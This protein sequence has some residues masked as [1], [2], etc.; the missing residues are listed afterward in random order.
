MENQDAMVQ[1]RPKRRFR[2]GIVIL[3]LILLPFLVLL[4]G[5]GF[6]YF[7]MANAPLELDDPRQ[8]VAADPISAEERFRFSASGRTVQIRMEKS[9]I[10][11]LILEQTGKDFPENINRELSQWYVSVS[12]CGIHIDPEGIYVDVELFYQDIRL[13]AKIP[14]ALEIS[15]RKLTLMPTG[16]KLGAFDL[17]VEELL[18]SAK[19]EMELVLPVICDVTHMELAQDAILLTGGVEEDIRKLVPLDEKYFRTVAFTDEMKAVTDT[20][21]TPEDFSALL[22]LLEQDPGFAETY[23]QGLFTVAEPKV[24]AEYLDKRHGLTQRF[25]PGIDF[26]ATSQAQITLSKKA[27][28]MTD[29]IE[30]YFTNLTGDYND[31]QFRLSNGR[32][33]LRG[34]VFD[35]DRY[36]NGTYDTMFKTLDPES[37]FL[38][39]VNVEDGFI[40]NTPSFAQIGNQWQEY[41]QPVDFDRT[42]ILGCVFRGVSGEP[43]LLYNRELDF[44]NTY[45]RQIA[46]VQLT[47]EAVSSLQ[48]PGKIGVWTG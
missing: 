1:K 30:L 32:F 26:E 47:E 11:S 14:C 37:F 46:M 20:L 16:V 17:P 5:A 27:I 28:H 33:Y 18:S 12:G 6:L 45:S 39:L 19:L 35:A 7:S 22:T 38:V 4:G 15:G 21:K 9:D 48:V 8:L 36:G 24:S 10:W 42:Y 31:K 43:F 34:S 25:F 2:I 23:Y 44:G 13:T 29:W 41:T 3:V 40:R